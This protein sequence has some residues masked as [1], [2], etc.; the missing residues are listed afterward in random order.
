MKDGTLAELHLSSL[1]AEC[2]AHY[3]LA[4]AVG[5]LSFKLTDVIGY[6]SGAA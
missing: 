5:P 1:P 2:Y 4:L 6:V 3:R